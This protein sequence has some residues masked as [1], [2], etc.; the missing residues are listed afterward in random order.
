MAQRELARA[1]AACRSTG[2]TE[3]ELVDYATRLVGAHFVMYSVLR[4][5][6]SPEVAFRRRRGFCTQYNG[7]LALVLQ[8]LGLQ[9]WLVY[10]T[11]VRFDDG[12]DWTLGHT[13]VRV[14]TAGEVRDVCAR[15][16]ANSSGSVHF[17]PIGEVRELNRA[18][19]F[20]TT[21]ASFGAAVAA[22]TRARVLGRPRPQW[23][24]HPRSAP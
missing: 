21:V 16:L 8:R 12:P 23:V 15:S 2:L 24:E 5:W 17:V 11:R 19:R 10:A 20:L 22:I 13:W 4:P 18:T 7:A 6:E 3:W 1:A 14:R 9:A